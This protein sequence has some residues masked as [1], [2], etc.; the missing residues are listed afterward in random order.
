MSHS[1]VICEN[2]CFSPTFFIAKLF[3]N[4]FL[5]L[6][7]STYFIHKKTLLPSAFKDFYLLFEFIENYYLKLLDFARRIKLKLS[8][9]VGFILSLD[10]ILRLKASGSRLMATTYCL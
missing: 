6:S 3:N 9:S 8:P 10:L 5:L 2:H 7:V 4:G 1:L